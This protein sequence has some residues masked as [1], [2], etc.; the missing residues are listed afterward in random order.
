[1]ANFLSQFAEAAIVI[2]VISFIIVPLV[3]FFLV[4]K[5]MKK[6]FP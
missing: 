5:I 1:M 6:T 4:W 2:A 3:G